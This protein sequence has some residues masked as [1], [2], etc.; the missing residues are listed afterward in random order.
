MSVQDLLGELLE[1]Y[2]Q[3]NMAL[4]CTSAHLCVKIVNILFVLKVK[5]IEILPR[6]IVPLVIYDRTNFKFFFLSERNK[7]EETHD[8]FLLNC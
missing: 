3:L 1:N 2:T 7:L 5:Y 4:G 8:F 6:Q